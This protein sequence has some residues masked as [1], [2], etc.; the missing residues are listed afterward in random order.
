ME[1]EEQAVQPRRLTQKENFSRNQPVNK[2]IH[3]K[4]PYQV[5]NN[6]RI[7]DK[8]KN[9]RNF[10]QHNYYKRVQKPK[11]DKA[12]PVESGSAR[13]KYNKYGND[14]KKRSWGTLDQF[15]P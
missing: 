11:K 13:G 5:L 15:R 14:Y 1:I 4:R 9:T 8:D 7:A 3:L 6:G 12:Q 10:S 2:R